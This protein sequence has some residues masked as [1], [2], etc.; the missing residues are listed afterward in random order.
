ME[1]T[2]IKISPAKIEGARG[3]FKW[4]VYGEYTKN[5]AKQRHPIGNYKFP[6]KRGAMRYAE[7]LLEN[8]FGYDTEYVKGWGRGKYPRRLRRRVKKTP[9]RNVLEPH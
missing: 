4:A 6:T 3:L 5:G 1:R 7:M 8:P 2:K 9:V